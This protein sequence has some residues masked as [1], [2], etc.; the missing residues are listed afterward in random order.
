MRQNRKPGFALTDERPTCE[1]CDF[2]KM[3][4]ENRYDTVTGA[5]VEVMTPACKYNPVT[6]AVYDESWCS[7]WQYTGIVYRGKGCK[8]REG[9]H[10]RR[11]TFDDQLYESMKPEVEDYVD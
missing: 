2:F 11:V 5:T 6:V 9:R 1:F 10:L 7:N 4:P 3:E 8:M